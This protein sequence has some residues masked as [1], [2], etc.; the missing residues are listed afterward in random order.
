MTKLIDYILNKLGLIRRSEYKKVVLWCQ[1]YQ[2]GCQYCMG[3]F[4]IMTAQIQAFKKEL[5]IE[6]AITRTFDDLGKDYQKA[7]A[8]IAELE[9]EKQQQQPNKDK[10]LKEMWE[11]INKNNVEG[12]EEEEPEWVKQLDEQQPIDTDKQVVPGI[13]GGVME[14]VCQKAFTPDPRCIVKMCPVHPVLPKKEE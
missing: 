12:K 7:L 8:R 14:C 2:E 9:E 11:V 4:E 10:T 13:H 5:E 6:Q 1:L 3:K